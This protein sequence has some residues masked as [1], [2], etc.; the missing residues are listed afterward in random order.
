[1]TKKLLSRTINLNGMTLAEVR[2]IFKGDPI[3]SEKLRSLLDAI[4]RPEKSEEPPKAV[5]GTVRRR[6]RKDGSIAFDTWVLLGT[7]DGK[8]IRRSVTSDTLEGSQRR[9]FELVRAREEGTPAPPSRREKRPTVGEYLQ[10]WLDIHGLA[11]TASSLEGYQKKIKAYVLTP[12]AGLPKISGIKLTSLDAR[13]IETL[14]SAMLRKG[15]SAQTVRH[16]HSILGSAL[17]RAMQ[18]KILQHNVLEFVVV[19]RAPKAEISSLGWAEAVKLLDAAKGSKIGALVALALYTGMRRSELKALTWKD[20]DF[21][22]GDIYVRRAIRWVNGLGNVTDETKTS[23]SRRRIE[24]GG[25]HHVIAML[26]GMRRMR[27]LE[28]SSVVVEIED[29]ALIFSYP[30]GSVW[31]DKFINNHFKKLLNEGGLPNMGLHSLRHTHASL[32]LADGEDVK[33]VS[34]RLGHASVSIT[35]DVYSHAIAGSQR[36]ASDRF[37]ESIEN[38]RDAMEAR[39][40]TL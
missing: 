30:N 21:T 22:T 19:P 6:T 24:L 15:L 28:L 31:G 23:G 7:K 26:A 14:Y 27:E 33:N 35:Y 1:M 37:A 25:G 10:S 8:Q 32:S 20:V 17:K 9:A 18:Q 13:Q 5:V 36:E 16:L 29:D 11:V 12:A 39:L 38:A 4:D 3:V 34:R 40:P 2:K